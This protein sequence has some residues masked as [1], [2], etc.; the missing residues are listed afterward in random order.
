MNTKTQHTPGP[1]G[2]Y[3][4]SK[5]NLVVETRTGILVANISGDCPEVE[6][7]ASLIAAA[8]ELL[9]ALKSVAEIKGWFEKPP[10]SA[11]GIKVMAAIAKAEGTK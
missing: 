2:A 8:P 5:G 6:A 4:L 10:V 1:W 7:N 3:N 11:S 9:A